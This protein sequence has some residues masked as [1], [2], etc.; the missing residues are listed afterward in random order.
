MWLYRGD[1]NHTTAHNK[2]DVQFY[3]HRK[4]SN[5]TYEPHQSPTTK[6]RCSIIIGNVRIGVINHTTAHN[7]TDVQFHHHRKCSNW[8]Y[9]PHQSPTTKQKCSFIIIR[10]E[11]L[12]RLLCEE[13]ESPCLVNAAQIHTS[14][15]A[16]ADNAR[17]LFVFTCLDVLMI[18]EVFM[19]TCPIVLM[20]CVSVYV[21]LPWCI[22]DMCTFLCLP[23][24]M[25]W[26]Y[27][28]SLSLTEPAVK[29]AVV[30]SRS[31]RLS[32]LKV[33]CPGRTEWV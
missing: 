7:K 19:F 8:S 11:G 22:D 12:P 29:A 26:W 14:S 6:Q 32:I 31:V 28:K 9:E 3:H 16:H 17:N 24:L 27:L 23:A 2:T 4:C 21:Y 13:S 1:V 33:A 20:I 30:I 15:A 5:W 18:S 10:N 25:Y